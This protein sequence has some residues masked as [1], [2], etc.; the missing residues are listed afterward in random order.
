MSKIDNIMHLVA[1]LQFLLVSYP[2]TALASVTDAA[3]TA[4]TTWGACLTCNT[5]TCLLLAGQKD[6]MTDE[7]LSSNEM[8]HLVMTARWRVRSLWI[9]FLPLGRSF[10]NTKKQRRRYTTIESC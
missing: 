10:S 7:T 9:S 5:I 8:G 1:V 2:M 3:L 4:E 6:V